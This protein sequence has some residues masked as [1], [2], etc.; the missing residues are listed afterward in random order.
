MT[1]IN[2]ISGP[3]GVS[4]ITFQSIKI[5]NAVIGYYQEDKQAYENRDWLRFDSGKLLSGLYGY[6]HSKTGRLN[7]IGF[8]EH[9]TACTNMFINQLGRAKVTWVSPLPGVQAAVPTVT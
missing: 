6:V 9:D 5:P 2:V 8:I 1:N 3:Y 7:A 4:Q